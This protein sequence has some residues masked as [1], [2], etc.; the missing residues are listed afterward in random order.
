MNSIGPN[1]FG[2][3]AGRRMGSLFGVMIGKAGRCNEYSG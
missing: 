3:E 2:V 1:G